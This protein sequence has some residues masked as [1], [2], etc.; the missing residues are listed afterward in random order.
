M[1]SG[2]EPT[3]RRVDAPDEGARALGPIVDDR[4]C[5]ACG[6]SLRG[7][8]PE[9][10]CPE[11]GASVARSLQGDLL[12]FCDP[13]YVRAMRRGAALLFWSTISAAAVMVIGPFIPFLLSLV[14]TSGA[15]TPATPAPTP[16]APG[17]QSAPATPAPAPS[18][19]VQGVGSSGVT[20]TTGPNTA[21][22]NIQAGAL[23]TGRGGAVGGVL[24]GLWL[25]LSVAFLVGWWLLTTPD[26]GRREGKAGTL[27]RRIVRIALSASVGAYAAQAALAALVYRGVIPAPFTPPGTP[28]AGGLAGLFGSLA[29][30]VGV[31]AGLSAVAASVAGFA[32]V[33]RLGRRI[34]DRK[35]SLRA[36]TLRWMTLVLG[37]IWLVFM[38]GAIFFGL[39]AAGPIGGGPAFRGAAG[40]QSTLLWVF[41]LPLGCI[42]LVLMAVSFFMFL[43][44]CSR[45]IDL[46]GRDSR[47]A[48]AMAD[49]DG[50]PPV[51]EGT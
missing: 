10:L 38:I 7:L 39:S 36:D 21:T 22:V 49:A 43:A 23:M 12:R 13:A 51:P 34:P 29:P 47:T 5:V 37:A 9:S 28:G 1:A 4:P 31:L 42:S 15:P 6:Y 16:S 25:A 2:D 33:R 41:A 50:A 17:A 26:P 30:S 35:V 18:G 27:T 24:A 46:L 11:C 48:L 14:L 45:L 44:L 19:A 8:T 20:M 32:H 3:I 40:A